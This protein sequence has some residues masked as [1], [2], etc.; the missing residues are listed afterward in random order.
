[1][2]ILA[3]LGLVVVVPLVSRS[4][5]RHVY[6]HQERMAKINYKHR[7]KMEKFNRKFPKQ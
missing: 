6:K 2:I 5:T 3:V 1:M 4:F 7:I